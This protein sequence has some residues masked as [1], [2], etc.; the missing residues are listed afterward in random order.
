LDNNNNEILQL[1][2]FYR[3]TDNL[4]ESDIV[5]A[6]IKIWKNV[7]KRSEVDQKLKTAIQ[8]LQF[9]DE[10]LSQIVYKLLKLL[11]ILPVTACRTSE[12]SF[13]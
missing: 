10:Y 8:F 5:M 12:K 9:C 1:I 4:T 13:S 7:L 3:D 6:K 11:C 2:D